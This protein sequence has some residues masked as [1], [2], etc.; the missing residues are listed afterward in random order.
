VGLHVAQRVDALLDSGRVDALGRLI[1][2]RLVRLSGQGGIVGVRQ[3]GLGIAIDFADSAAARRFVRAA[4]SQYGL[5]YACGRA[6]N[7]VKLY[8]PYTTTDAE[9]QEIVN[10]IEAVQAHSMTA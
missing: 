10:F 7:V 9:A 4:R 1:G 5:V 6:G 8:P 2:A 3:Y